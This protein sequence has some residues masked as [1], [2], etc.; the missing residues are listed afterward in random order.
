MFRFF[1]LHIRD[2]KFWKT[3]PA[4]G[5]DLTEYGLL[6]AL[7][8]IVVIAAVIFFGDELSIFWS[9]MADEVAGILNPD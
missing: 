3:R 2:W 7:I 6:V 4:H 9:E 1:N 8:A 5:Q